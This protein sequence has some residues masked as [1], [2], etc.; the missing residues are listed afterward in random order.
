M[1]DTVPGDDGD[2]NVRA[3]NDEAIKDEVHQQ[4]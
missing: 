2:Q 1:S 4:L 3:P